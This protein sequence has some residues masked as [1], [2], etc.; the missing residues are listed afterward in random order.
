MCQIFLAT[1]WRSL[2]LGANSSDRE[3]AE[4]LSDDG[5]ETRPEGKLCIIKF[6]QEDRRDI[7]V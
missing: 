5:L 3:L 4:I 2:I 6:N 1:L 7:L